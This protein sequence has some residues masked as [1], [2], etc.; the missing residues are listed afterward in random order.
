MTW[1]PTWTLTKPTQLLYEQLMVKN[2]VP[3]AK[4]RTARSSFTAELTELL[5]WRWLMQF[6]HAYW[7]VILQYS[8]GC[9]WPAFVRYP[10]AFDP[11]NRHFTHWALEEFEARVGPVL[12]SHHELRIPPGKLGCSLEGAGKRRIFAIGN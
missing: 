11:M 7:N 5:S 4:A 6:T 12:P 1:E 10:F 9:L 8:Q 2:G 3:P